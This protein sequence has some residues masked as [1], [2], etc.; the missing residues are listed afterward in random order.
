MTDALD[1]LRL[2]ARVLRRAWGRLV[3]LA[4]LAAWIAWPL[5]GFL[6]QAAGGTDGPGLGAFGRVF[7]EGRPL[8]VLKNTVAVALPASLMALAAGGLAGGLLARA[9]VP[10][11]RVWLAGLAAGAA[12][13]PYLVGVAW[14]VVSAPGAPLA[15]AL[16]VEGTWG[17]ASVLASWL[18]PVVA[19]VAV[20]TFSAAGYDAEEAALMA[21]GPWGALGSVT[22][23]LAAP[24]LASAWAL[25][26]VLAAV[27][28]SVADLA[29]VHVYP[30][31]IFTRFSAYHDVGAAAAA[32]VPLAGLLAAAWGLARLAR[33]RGAPSGLRLGSA[34][35][36]RVEPRTSGWVD[37]LALA[38]LALVVAWNPGLPLAAFVWKAGG[39]ARY[40]D[41]LGAAGE[42]MVFSGW[43]A[44][45]TALLVTVSALAVVAARLRHGR[46]LLGEL[47]GR[48]AY[49]S[50]FVPPSV[51]GIA[52]VEQWSG[53]SW[54][55]PL[56]GTALGLAVGLAARVLPV[57]VKVLETVFERLDPELEEAA[58]ACGVSPAQSLYGILLPLLLPAMGA[59]AVLGALLSLGEVDLA[60]LLT[61]P[62]QAPV[63]VRI[64]NFLHY[65]MD[66]TL[67]ACCALM[68][69]AVGAGALGLVAISSLA[70]RHM[71][72][73]GA[74]P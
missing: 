50:F 5:V 37:A 43:T 62:G 17:A 51:L 19:L 56:Y 33:P 69:L 70:V 7:G 45:L 11:P 57:G 30:V 73:Q 21:R 49:L 23:P 38:V 65:G 59:V 14:Q 46:G 39:P 47:C 1:R 58:W 10:W 26:F 4:L 35:G 36:R 61:P 67:A 29:C 12:L 2:L 20:A 3:V 64:F 72:R 9:R 55:E 16:A 63:M 44:L 15:G 48:L 32:S 6:G 8:M 31:E 66:E 68:V 71:S 18:A 42:D 60:V 28:Y 24:G 52:L 34:L 74:A 27:N 25:A 40:T 13:P 22:L 53:W 54:A 41:A